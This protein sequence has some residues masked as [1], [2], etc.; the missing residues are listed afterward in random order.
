MK[1]LITILF[2]LIFCRILSAQEADTTIAVTDTA[3]VSG[4]DTL[5]VPS[6]DIDT[7]IYAESTDSL[8]FYVREREMHI[9]GNARIQYKQTDLK[10]A[11]I[12]VDFNTNFIDAEGIPSDTMPGRMMQT[13]VLSEAG[14]IYEG[15]KM[16]YN[17]KTQRGF[18][19]AAETEMEGGIYT[20]A[21]INKV[22]Q[23][24][25]FIEDG[26]YTTCDAEEPHYHFY[27]NEMKVIHRQEVIAKWIWLNFGQVPFPIPF[28]FAVFPIES[29]RRSGIL[30]PAF[31][32]TGDRG[33]YF[34]RFGYFWAISDY[35]DVNFTGDYFTRG[36][37]NANSRF[38][39]AKRYLYSGHIEGGYSSIRRGENTDPNFS[40]ST[41]WRLR[42]IHN[43]TIDPT[44]RL[45]A[46]LEFTSGTD[47]L[48][49][50]TTDYRELLR[51]DIRSSATLF[52][53][54]DSGNSLSLS[55]NRNQNLQTGDI[56]EELPNLTF[57][58]TQQYPFRRTGRSVRDQA[59]YEMVGFRYNSSFRNNRVKR[60]GDL[61]IRGGIQHNIGINASPRAGYF[62]ITPNMNYTE[63]WYN[64]RIER[65]VT[66]DPQTGN[67]TTLTRDVHE[68]NMVRTFNSGVGISTKFFGFFQPG[69]LGIAAIRHQVTP[70]LSYNFTPDFSK[71]G[72]GYY[73][74]II[75]HR[76][77]VE[78]Y[79]PFA[80]EIYGG[81]GRGE[82]QSLNFSV[83]N[84]F[85]MKTTVD[86]TDT[87]SKERKIQL[88]NIGASLN[89]N[90]AADSMRLSP[91]NLGFRSQVAEWFSFQGNTV[92]SPYAWD[93]QGRQLN[94]YLFEDGGFLR[95]NSFSFSL[96]T[97]LSGERLKSA[98]DTLD[99]GRAPEG[100]YYLG[101]TDNR[102]LGGLYDMADADFTI[103]WD[104]S[105]SYNYNYQ[106]VTPIESITYSTLSGGINFNLTPNW[107]FSFSG[108][109]DFRSKDFAAPQVRISRD[110]HCW[111]MDFTW[112]PIGT[113]RGYRFEIR[114]K[115]PQL[116]DLKITKADQ[117]YSGKG[118]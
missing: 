11:N 114:V 38:R 83:D 34:S 116:Q 50:T 47:Y 100:Q 1:I 22:D 42:M 24:T 62:N 71:P 25:Y 93:D 19:T 35:M 10:S 44:M 31:G 57:S 30:P 40:E 63:R 112:T 55:Y 70:T 32:Q 79:D 49:Q 91:I 99:A 68:I 97:S 29:G 90:F 104:I 74:S 78:A 105:L 36:G 81:V 7:I 8:I 12:Y 52:K 28:P 96:N 20:G 13:P 58:M 86:P 2:L 51:N 5:P 23:E 85:E 16:R 53:T 84:N 4:I 6:T 89:Y 46:N 87:T 117:F 67:D 64:K 115:A 37:Y 102:G 3:A 69:I 39:Y 15:A 61:N 108:S 21:R 77:E 72:W 9:F 92:F 118:R 26:V 88:I 66:T 111:L 43:Q 106:R 17:F 56:N 101:S 80:R 103:P 107:K 73:E 94:R 82:S 48:L 113:F 41:E 33:F 109:Y 98:R 60:E 76:G 14:E 18:I 75:N 27:A 110:L 95:L 65:Y 59:W 54:W 45:D